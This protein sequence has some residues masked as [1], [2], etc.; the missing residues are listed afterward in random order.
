[1]PAN[2]L[3]AAD[4]AQEGRFVSTF[5]PARCW[6]Q[7]GS[8]AKALSE[9]WVLQSDEAGNLITLEL[10][11]AGGSCPASPTAPSAVSDI[12]PSFSSPLTTRSPGVRCRRCVS[13][14]FISEVAEK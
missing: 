5:L 6:A 3:S 11:P 8:D 14:E 9:A 13:T 12:S 2:A 10:S 1:V 7:A 4:S